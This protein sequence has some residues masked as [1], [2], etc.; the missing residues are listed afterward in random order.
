MKTLFFLSLFPFSLIFA[1]LISHIQRV[2]LISFPLPFLPSHTLSPLQPHIHL[3]H[4][5]KRPHALISTSKN[6]IFREHHPLH[7]FILPFFSSIPAIFFTFSI[8]YLSNILLCRYSILSDDISCTS[9]FSFYD[10]ILISRTFYSFL[11]DTSF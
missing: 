4:S 7:L 11:P 5:L 8:Q 10:I 1:S 2:G 9:F 6:P 3:T